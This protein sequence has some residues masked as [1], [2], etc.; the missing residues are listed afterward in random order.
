VRAARD[1]GAPVRVYVAYGDVGAPYGVGDV[2]AN[3]AAA[4]WLAQDLLFGKDKT[5]RDIR[6]LQ[7]HR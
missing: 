1:L 4:W 7:A 3:R 2:I 5:W 6:W